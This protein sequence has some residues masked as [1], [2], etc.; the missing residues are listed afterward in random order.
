MTS[1]ATVSRWLAMG[2][3]GYCWT[4]GEGIGRRR[5]RPENIRI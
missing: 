1:G 2:R 5:R 4:T 3:R